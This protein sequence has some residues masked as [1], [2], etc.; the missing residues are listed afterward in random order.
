MERYQQIFQNANDVIYTTDLE[1]NVTALN[2]AGEMLTGFRSDEILGKSIELMIPSE[3]IL[4]LDQMK[5]RMLDGQPAAIYE[6]EVQTRDGRRFPAETSTSL[7]VENGKPIG[8]LGILRDVSERKRLEQQL[9]L[10]QK[11]EAVGQL[12]GGIAHDFNNIITI[13]LGYTDIALQNLP[14]DHS[15]YQNV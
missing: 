1:H 11:M 6:V 9:W 4:V 14:A 3:Y 10:A 8:I 2:K 13:I 7:I 15:A 5:Q 12:A